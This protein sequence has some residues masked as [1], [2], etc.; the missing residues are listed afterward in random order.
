MTDTLIQPRGRKSKFPSKE[1]DAVSS[2]RKKRGMPT[3]RQN[4]PYY[5]FTSP[6]QSVGGLFGGSFN[7]SNGK[8][9]KHVFM[10]K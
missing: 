3:I 2:G 8:D 4:G 7:I 5:T 10:N 6:L 1:Q 9:L